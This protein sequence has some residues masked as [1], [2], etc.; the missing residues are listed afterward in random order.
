MVA[1][2]HHVR[3]KRVCGRYY[4][5]EPRWALSAAYKQH[6]WAHP[7]LGANVVQY[8][9]EPDVGESQALPS[10]WRIRI[11]EHNCFL[12]SIRDDDPMGYVQGVDDSHVN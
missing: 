3:M 12:I 6:R 9:L 4:V 11:V 1:V 10:F 8:L 5:G 2:F 7:N